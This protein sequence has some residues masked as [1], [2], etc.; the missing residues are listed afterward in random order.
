MA[1]QSA[2]NQ[3]KPRITEIF[4]WPAH[5]RATGR[6]WDCGLTHFNTHEVDLIDRLSLELCEQLT[7]FCVNVEILD[8]RKSTPVAPTYGLIIEVHYC[9]INKQQ[10]HAGYIC[11]PKQWE[12]LGNRI[13]KELLWGKSALASAKNIQISPCVLSEAEIPSIR[14]TAEIISG[15]ILE[16]MEE[17][18][19]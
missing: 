1:K 10:T 5:G 17:T 18:K 3:E 16:Y 19:K 12:E 15:I 9:Q 7:N 6:T 14:K 4:I 11:V 13:A 2:N 8:T